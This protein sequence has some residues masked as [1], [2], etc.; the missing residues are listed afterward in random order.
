M[1]EAMCA[2]VER[3]GAVLAEPSA[4]EGLVWADPARP[5]LFPTVVNGAD[6]L[7]WVQLP[8]AGIEP[9]AHHLDNRLRWTCGKGIYAPAVAETVLALILAT[10]KNLHGYSRASTWSGPVGRQLANSRVTVLG[11]GGIATS[12]LP[13]LAPFDCQTTVVRRSSAAF[14]GADYTV[15]VDLLDDV[16]P[17][18]D[19]LVLA[20]ALTRETTGIIDS[21]R[22]DLL[23]DDAWIVNVARGGHVVTEDLLVALTERSIGGAALDVTDP[24]PLPDDH[25]LWS[26]PNCLITPHI[27]NTPEMGLALLTPF[28]E[29]NVRRFVEHRDLLATV[30]VALG[31]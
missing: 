4:A 19:I 13:L 21:H 25:P 6:H 12:L 20:L 2:A 23:P 10:C 28:V 5:D 18:T 22:M 15:T 7:T 31:Y 3:A 14:A 26:L 8:Y 9:F 27:G 1:Y 24:E 29:E 11:G 30:D 17:L 16:L